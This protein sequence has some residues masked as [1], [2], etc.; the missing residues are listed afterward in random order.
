MRTKGII[1]ALLAT[2][3]ITACTPAETG[4]PTADVDQIYTA[5]AQTVIAELTQTAAVTTATSAATA[6]SVP[7]QETATPVPTSAIAI[8]TPLPTETATAQATIAVEATPTDQY[9]DNAAWVADVSVQ[10]GTEMSPGQAFE[11]TWRIKN[12]GTCT[13]TESYRLA[14]GYGEEMNGQPRTMNSTVAPNES[15]DV[16]VV[17][18]A[19]LSAGSYQSYWRMVNTA[20]ANF[21]EFFYVD[22]VVR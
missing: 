12:T 11:K 21:G 8:E 3:L 19:P 15:I 18:S 17:F 9:C 2:L 1:F 20:G 14:F 7:E 22:I 5:A 16:T 4:T 10:D 13:W 6:T